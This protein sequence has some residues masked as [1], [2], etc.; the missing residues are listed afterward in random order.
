MIQITNMN[1]TK[2]LDMKRNLLKLLMVFQ[3]V[4][5]VSTAQAIEDVNCGEVKWDGNPELKNKLF[6]GAVYRSCH[7]TGNFSEKSSKLFNFYLDYLQHNPSVLG[8][9][10]APY[11]AQ[12]NDLIGV[13]FKTKVLQKNKNGDMTIWLNGFLGSDEE[14]SL[15]YSTQSEKISGKRNSKY[16]QKIITHSHFVRNDGGFTLTLRSETHVKQPRIAPNKLFLRK[17]KSGI[18]KGANKAFD[19]E[20]LLILNALR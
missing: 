14:T 18:I 9:I 8:V 1:S 17:V 15:L 6:K 16:T 2:G 3:L 20:V 10:K 4:L 19:N 12:L 7:F 13:S 5:T 11:S